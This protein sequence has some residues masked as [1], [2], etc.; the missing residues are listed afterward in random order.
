MLPALADVTA[1][2]FF[3]V[4]I[5]I[6]RHMPFN[7]VPAWARQLFLAT[8][9]VAEFVRIPC[10]YEKGNSHEF[11]DRQEFVPQPLALLRYYFLLCGAAGC[12][13]GNSTQPRGETLSSPRN[14]AE[15]GVQRM[16]MRFLRTSCLTLAVA[17]IATAARADEK[18]D[19][20]RDIRPILSDACFQ[21]HGPDEKVRKA[22]LRLDTR[23]GAF[24]QRDSGT[25]LVPGKPDESEIYARI[26]SDDRTTLM[27]PPKSGKSLT[28]K[29]IALIKKWI[30]E[31]AKWNSHWAFEPP[32][33]PA[34]PQV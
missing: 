34:L 29:Q 10:A 14:F 24:A 12:Y 31:G 22:D 15:C 17:A 13:T 28:P 7:E 3:N 30:E 4:P 9:I 21:C 2:W 18:V 1:G 25:L 32:Q 16:Y 5:Q 11:H 6:W 26:T 20:A 33:R 23:Q 27:P 19:F 8:C